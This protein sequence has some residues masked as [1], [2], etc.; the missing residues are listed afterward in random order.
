[1][2]DTKPWN[3]PKIEN[4]ILGSLTVKRSKASSVRFASEQSVPGHC[5]EHQQDTVGE[6][7]AATR[8]EAPL[9]IDDESHVHVYAGD[10]SNTDDQPITVASASH[11]AYIESEL[12]VRKQ[13]AFAGQDHQGRFVIHSVKKFDNI[14]ALRLLGKPVVHPVT[15]SSLY[16]EVLRRPLSASRGLRV[17]SLGVG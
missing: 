9:D 3:E 6:E 7:I 4:L 17:L 8:I 15:G 16:H 2:I 14:V 12:I 10:K 5:A 11:S 1:V 13:Q